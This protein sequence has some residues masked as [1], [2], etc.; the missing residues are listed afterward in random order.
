MYPVPVGSGDLM[1]VPVEGQV[2][3]ESALPGATHA[4][5]STWQLSWQGLRGVPFVCYSVVRIL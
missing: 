3:Q 4:A 5:P 1:F 2:A